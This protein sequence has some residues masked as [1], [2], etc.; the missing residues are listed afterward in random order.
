MLA[1]PPV[2]RLLARQPRTVDARLLSRSDADG[3]SALNV[4]DGIGLGVFERD[5]RDGKID[6]RLIGQLLLVRH[7]ICKKVVVDDKLVAPLLKRNA[8]HLLAFQ[9]PRL[10]TLVDLDDIVSALLFRL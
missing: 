2:V 3:L 4:A 10:V 7:N 9:R 6:F 5:H 8:V 1:Q